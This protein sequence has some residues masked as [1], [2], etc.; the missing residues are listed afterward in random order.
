MKRI[1]FVLAL[2]ATV[3]CERDSLIGCNMMCAPA[4]VLRY[5]NHACFCAQPCSTQSNLDAGAA[6]K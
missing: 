4:P 1:V 6:K 5:E 3:G 2:L